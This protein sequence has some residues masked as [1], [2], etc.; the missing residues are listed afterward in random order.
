MNIAT[1]AA[2]IIARARDYYQTT[3]PENGGGPSADAFDFMIAT[4]GVVR[5]GELWQETYSLANE[6]WQT[7]HYTRAEAVEAYETFESRAEEVEAKL[8]ACEARADELWQRVLPELEAYAA[9]CRAARY[10]GWSKGNGPIR[11]VRR[12]GQK[13]ADRLP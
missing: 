11:R 10:T 6:A 9:D 1:A 7:P 4:Q 5:G 12:G 8:A 3:P 13:Q 2:T